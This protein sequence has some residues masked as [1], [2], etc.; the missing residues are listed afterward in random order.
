[1]PRTRVSVL[2]VRVPM[3]DGV[4]LAADLALVE[5]APPRP[6]LLVRSPYLR[7]GLRQGMDLVGLAEAGWVVVGQDCRGRGDSGGTFEPCVDDMRDGYDTVAWCAA[8]P[9][10]D[11]RVA[12][13][14]G[15]YLGWTQWAAAAARPPAL[16]AI[17][18]S[19]ITPRIPRHWAY[20]GG[21]FTTGLTSLW[22]TQMAA[23]DARA[24]PRQRQRAAAL[25]VDWRAL[26]EAPPAK[27]PARSMLRGFDRWLDPGA[28]EHW[29]ALDLARH[30]RRMDQPCFQVAGW[31]DVFCEGSL[32]AWAALR[33]L[34]PSD[35]ARASQRL[36]I[37]PWTHTGMYFQLTPEMDFGPA[38]NGLA[39][40]LPAE[41]LAWLRRA[42]DREPVP[43]GLRLFV[44]GSGE[45]RDYQEWPPPATPLRLFL[46]AEEGANS[47]AGDGRLSY[48]PGAAGTDR[49]R[50]DP[51]DP[52]PTRGGRIM[53][54]WLPLAGP[55]D[56]RPVEVREDVLV[57]TSDV[58]YGDVTVIGPVEATVAF[59]TTGESADVTV[60]L[61][62]VH[63]D[64]CA[65]NVLDSVRRERFTPGRSR[66]VKVSL[67]SVAQ[68]FR[69]GHR[70]RVEVSSSNFPRFDR[71][72][73]T[74]QPPGEVDRWE[75]AWQTVHRGG[76]SASSISLPVV[77][78]L[79]PAARP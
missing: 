7:A 36:V 12:M 4:K 17:S 14:G 62:D 19:V 49:F 6:A 47:S 67:G 32:D 75:G 41:V 59:E 30:Y 16:R 68:T 28:R 10:C 34:A 53:G 1:M 55:V 40:G 78:A 39:A 64:G 31:Y 8:Q 25:A 48:A 13:T 74:A 51:K 26:V 60:K 58:L 70:I 24:T 66:R 46:D 18:P 22:W 52:V 57:Y 5:G 61:V 65:F 11:G 21:A 35:Y 77:G 27:H 23:T 44:M 38:A 73:S 56:Q 29:A 2:D 3:R 76:R 54:P 20:E 33:R 45:W 42:V 9:W 37:G 72:P 43:G 63:P 79:P 71:N 15:S 50:Y 69:S